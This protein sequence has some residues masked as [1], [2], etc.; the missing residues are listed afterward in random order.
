MGQ[1]RSLHLSGGACKHDD[2]RKVTND[3][4]KRREG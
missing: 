1:T 4:K 2:F 3:I